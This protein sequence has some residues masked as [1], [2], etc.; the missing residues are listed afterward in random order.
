MQ[1]EGNNDSCLI[2]TAVEVLAF[3]TYFHE[4]KHKKGLLPL[5]A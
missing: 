4:D 3:Y 1:S 2:P 5:A